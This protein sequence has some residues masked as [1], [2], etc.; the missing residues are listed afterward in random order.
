KFE[1]DAEAFCIGELLREQRLQA[2]LTQKELADQVGTP[3]TTIS[4]LERGYSDVSL[5]SIFQ[6]FA[7]MG[8]KVAVTLL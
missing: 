3:V 5:S 2:G 1:A 7:G 8:R 6:I 4:R